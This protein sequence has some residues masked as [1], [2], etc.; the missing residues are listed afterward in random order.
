MK[1]GVN[2]WNFS[3]FTLPFT[4][5]R[6][7]LPFL[8]TKLFYTFV[9]TLPVEL[10][11]QSVTHSPFA[12][13]GNKRKILSFGSQRKF[14]AHIEWYRSTISQSQTK[15]ITRLLHANTLNFTL[16][17][18]SKCTSPYPLPNTLNHWIIKK[19]CLHK[20]WKTPMLTKIVWLRKHP[21]RN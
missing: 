1:K 2:S 17:S 11:P 6:I 7:S 15:T 3:I 13:S 9:P 18:F 16:H 19:Y 5:H 4:H 21:K 14:R 20:Q 12:L 10:L 8:E